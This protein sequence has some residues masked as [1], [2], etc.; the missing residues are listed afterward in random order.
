MAI[1]LT[2]QFDHLI[3]VTRDGSGAWVGRA[4]IERE[5]RTHPGLVGASPEL[6]LAHGVVTLHPTE[7][8]FNP[9]GSSSGHQGVAAASFRV[10]EALEAV[11]E[12]GDRLRVWRGGTAELGVT[13]FRDGRFILGFGTLVAMG[14]GP[15][16]SFTEDPRATQRD[17]HRRVLPSVRPTDL[18]VRI[19]VDGVTA[20][21]REGEYAFNEPWHLFVAKVFT[22]GLPGEFS[23]LAIAR[24]HHALTARMLMDS[25]LALSSSRRVDITWC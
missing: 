25:T 17:P 10:G 6:R 3:T 14:P 11:H 1:P 15:G 2:T 19:T 7:S 16:I 8:D 24:D 4:D 18:Y 13:V 21:L 22:R 20:Q 9:F 5:R 23:Q 12:D